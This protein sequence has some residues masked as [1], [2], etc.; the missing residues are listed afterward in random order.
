[1]AENANKSDVAE[2]LTD[3]LKRAVAA[4]EA[5]GVPYLLGG[6]LGCWARGGPPSSNDIDLMLKRED[7]LRAQE[8]LTE[9]GMRPEDPPEQWLLKAWDGDILVDL[10][11]EPSG[12]QIDEETLAR[13]EDLS[14]MAMEVRVMALDD[15]LVTKL[16]ALDEHSAD[17][18]DLLLIA[19]SLRE[20]IDWEVLRERTAASPFAAA[21][22]TLADGLKISTAPVGG[23]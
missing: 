9:A 5:R 10:I 21:F 17:Y 11:F 7:A 20:Q 14:V 12:L 18:R 6:G 16:M 1:M 8:A 19:R 3:S 15:I 2:E 23:R 4:L 13:G 22:F